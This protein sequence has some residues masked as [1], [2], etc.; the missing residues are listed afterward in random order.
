M[1][2]YFSSL[3]N[4]PDDEQLQ[5]KLIEPRTNR[6]LEMQFESKTRKSIGVQH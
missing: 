3:D 4:M 5:E 6:T 2:P 1:N